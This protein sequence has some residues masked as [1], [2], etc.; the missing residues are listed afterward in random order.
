MAVQALGLTARD[1]IGQATVDA[2]N[3]EVR[4]LLDEHNEQLSAEDAMERVADQHGYVLVERDNETALM[5]NAVG[6]YATLWYESQFGQA[7]AIFSADD[8]END[9][10]GFGNQVLGWGETA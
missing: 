3:A 8:Y 5:H 10:V 6:E 7:M 1:M 4:A 2:L 9:G